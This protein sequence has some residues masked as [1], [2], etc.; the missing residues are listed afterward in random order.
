MQSY[1][2]CKQSISNFKPEII[3]QNES[4]FKDY[5][6][7]TI[8][9]CLRCNA[10]KTITVLKKFNPVQSRYQMYEDNLSLFTSLFQPIVN[11]IYSIQKKGIVLDVGCSS[12]L[13]MQLL[14]KKGYDVYGIEPNKNAW[15]KV[16]KYFNKNVFYGTLNSYEKKKNIPEFDIIIFNHVLEHIEKIHEQIKIAKKLL[17][18]HGLLIVGIP[19]VRNIIFMLR[20]KYWEPL[21]PK[22]HIWHLTDHYMQSLIEE[23]GFKT[24]LKQYS[25]DK[26]Q[27]YHQFKKIYFK[28]LSIVNKIIFSGES[29]VLYCK[30]N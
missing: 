19:N 8:A 26:R 11:R 14:K 2:L 3:F 9:K 28:L 17:K 5:N 23:L 12:G 27:D 25:D 24:I 7:I 22:E 16:Y 10:L 30:K 18:P 15:N 1:C 20:Q 29:V 13:L 21:M 6:G 4:T